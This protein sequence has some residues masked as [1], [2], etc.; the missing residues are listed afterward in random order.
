MVV[1]SFTILDARQNGCSA[2]L[3]GLFAAAI[4]FKLGIT[5][6]ESSLATKVGKCINRTLPWN[7]CTS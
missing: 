2:V 6:I 1:S 3:D 4:S 5:Q 7:I